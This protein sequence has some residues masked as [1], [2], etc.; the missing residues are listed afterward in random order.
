MMLLTL[1]LVTEPQREYLTEV[2]S[3]PTPTVGAAA[4]IAS[5]G[6]ACIARL[7][8]AGSEGELIISRD[9]QGG[10][11]VARNVTDYRDGL[12][13]WKIRSRVTFEAREGRF[14][15]SHSQIERFNDQS[16]GSNVLGASPWQPVGKWRGSGWQKAHDALAGQSQALSNCI[17][18]ASA[19]SDW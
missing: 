5:R 18:Q 8:S 6:E 4:E 16:F 13:I 17:T 3:E 2:V 12:V 7:L 1:L 11:L 10:T 14:R 15:I 19:S 9:V